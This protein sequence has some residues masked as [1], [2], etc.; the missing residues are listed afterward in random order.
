M[1]L[2]LRSANVWIGPAA[3][4]TTCRHS[5]NKLAMVRSFLSGPSSAQ[6]PVPAKAQLATSDWAI[7][8]SIRSDA[9]M[10][11]FSTEPCVASA[12]ATNP[13]TPQL[14]PSSQGSESA[15]LEMALASTPPISKKLPAV[16]AAPMR[17]NRTSCASAGA[18]GHSG[19]AI[20]TAANGLLQRRPNLENIVSPGET[21]ISDDNTDHL[22]LQHHAARSGASEG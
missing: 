4:T 6:T 14:P 1:R 10:R 11:R 17:K 3:R 19:R 9:T 20:M 18:V 22:G 16:A 7:P 13:G 12:T 21:A 15:G 2:P 8:D 5:G